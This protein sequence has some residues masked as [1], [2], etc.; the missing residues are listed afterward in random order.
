MLPPVLF[1]FLCHWQEFNEEYII[2]PVGILFILSGISLRI[3]SQMHLKYRLKEHKTLTTTGPYAFI[4][5]P[6]YIANTLLILGFCITT[7]LAWFVPILV[8]WCAVIY[9]LVVRYEEGHLLEKYGKPYLEYMKSV[10]R[11]FPRF[12]MKRTKRKKDVSSF[13]W[14]SMRAEAHCLFIIVPSLFKELMSQL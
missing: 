6:I 11:W 3:H 2:W 1:C 7:K 10:P 12:D 8:T 5:N 13:F 14:P 9:T 4:R